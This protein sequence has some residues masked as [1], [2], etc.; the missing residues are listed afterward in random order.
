MR[1]GVSLN[2][3]IVPDLPEGL[4]PFATQSHNISHTRLIIN[5]RA[6]P[7]RPYEEPVFN[8]L[9]PI[10]T[11]FRQN[12]YTMN[13]LASPFPNC[14]CQ[15]PLSI[16]KSARANIDQLSIYENESKSP[17]VNEF[18]FEVAQ[19]M[20]LFG[21][22]KQGKDCQQLVPSCEMFD[23]RPPASTSKESAAVWT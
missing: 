20:G 5:S 11:M 23:V 12:I 18:I 4:P 14:F 19:E 15:L 22:C 3:A 2:E 16:N 10:T 6:F 8:Y 21:R 7:K 1:K 13:C 9:F 17:V